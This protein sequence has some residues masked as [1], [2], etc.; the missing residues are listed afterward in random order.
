MNNLHNFL[1]EYY[2]L[3]KK[4]NTQLFPK[5]DAELDVIECT[6]NNLIAEDVVI[7]DQSNEIHFTNEKGTQTCIIVKDDLITNLVPKLIEGN[8][9][10]FE[11]RDTVY[12]GIY[13]GVSY[14]NKLQ[15]LYIR[16]INN[17]NQVCSLIF[18]FSEDNLII[19]E[20]V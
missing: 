17:D 19:T 12:T 2:H 15:I 3:C 9:Y 16:Y 8:V 5:L 20:Y 4:Y 10:K 7:L 1:I 13:S 11:I 18:D 14:D 6:N